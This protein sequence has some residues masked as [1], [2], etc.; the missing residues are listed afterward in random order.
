MPKLYYRRPLGTRT[1]ASRALKHYCEATRQNYRFCRD[2]DG[3]D[4]VCVSAPA[5]LGGHPPR[6]FVEF[7]GATIELKNK[8]YEVSTRYQQEPTR[9]NE[10]FKAISKASTLGR[11]FRGPIKLAPGETRTNWPEGLIDA[12]LVA[13]KYIEELDELLSEVDA[14]ARYEEDKL[15]TQRGEPRPAFSFVATP[16]SNDFNI[17]A[18]W[19]KSGELVRRA[20]FALAR[21]DG[22][23]AALALHDLKSLLEG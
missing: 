19:P 9:L 13:L 7:V 22:D 5:S 11:L 21:F 14:Y 15:R 17:D 23:A 6:P 20:T 2:G 4:Y 8:F 18:T 1:P 3:R 16:P 12:A 10:T